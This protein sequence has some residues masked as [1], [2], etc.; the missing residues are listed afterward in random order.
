VRRLQIFA[1]LEAGELAGDDDAL[2]LLG[3]TVFAEEVELLGS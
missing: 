1:V 2:D 3:L